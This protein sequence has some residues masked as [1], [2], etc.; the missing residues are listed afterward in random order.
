MNP[1]DYDN[2]ATAELG[3]KFG[4]ENSGYK[5]VKTEGK[6]ALILE[7]GDDINQLEMVPAYVRRK[8]KLNASALD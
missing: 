6:P 1:D 4:Q 2:E 8:K 5:Y 7:E 3:G